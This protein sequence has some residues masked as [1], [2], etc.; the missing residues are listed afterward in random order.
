M[1]MEPTR[2][3]KKPVTPP[4]P[5]FRKG[6]NIEAR[7]RGK[8]YFYAGRISKVHSDGTYDIDY[9]DGTQ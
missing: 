3:P 8:I 4:A 7:Y 1:V 6:D 2:P 5:A 9:N